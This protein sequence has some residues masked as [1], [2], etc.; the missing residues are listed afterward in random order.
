MTEPPAWKDQY[1]RELF[2]YERLMAR[3]IQGS[4]VQWQAPSLA[5]TAQA[6]LLRI[7]LGPGREPWPTTVVCVVGV[8][9]T[10]MAWQLMGRHRFYSHLDRAEMLRLEDELGLDHISDRGRQAA[11]LVHVRP[12]RLGSLSSFRV[13]RVGFLLVA[14]VDVLVAVSVWWR[15]RSLL[16]WRVTTATV[17]VGLLAALVWLGRRVVGTRSRA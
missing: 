7:A 12:P 17:A 4:A 10:A 11:R 16:E 1:A 8:L 2:T 5:L 13:W 14:V 6:F 3:S 15:P 9:I